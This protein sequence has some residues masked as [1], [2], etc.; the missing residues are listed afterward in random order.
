VRSG[1]NKLASL[2]L[3]GCHGKLIKLAGVMFY[4]HHLAN[5]R[6]KIL[7]AHEAKIGCLI[8]KLQQLL[9]SSTTENGLKLLWD[10]DKRGVIRLKKYINLQLRRLIKEVKFMCVSMLTLT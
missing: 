4:T 3:F 8:T 1:I 2:V 9:K 7:I 5:E 10:C 6:L